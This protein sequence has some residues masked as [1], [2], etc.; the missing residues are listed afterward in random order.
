MPAARILSACLVCLLA[1]FAVPCRALSGTTA[2]SLKAA[3][4][5]APPDRERAD[6]LLAL[7]A[8]Y[9]EDS[10]LHSFRFA[11]QAAN[12]ARAHRLPDAQVQAE[13]AI[14]ACHDLVEQWPAAIGRYRSARSIAIANGLDLPALQAE[15]LLSEAFNSAAALDSTLHWK[16]VAL[17]HARRGREL[18]TEAQLLTYLGG[19]YKDLGRKREAIGYWHAALA[20]TRNLQRPVAQAMALNN[21]ADTYLDLKATDSAGRA[22]QAALD[23]LRA[24][25]SPRIESYVRTS[26]G[27]YHMQAGRPALA[28]GATRDAVALALQPG[29]DRHVAE[30]ALLQLSDFY[31]RQS[32]PGP[33]L[34]HYKQYILQRDSNRDAAR[35]AVDAR[36][37]VKYRFELE[38]AYNE[39]ER[40]NLRATSRLRLDAL[41][42]AGIAFLIIAILAIYVYISLRQ[43]KRK[44]RT[45]S[46][47]AQ[48]LRDQNE[49]I[50]ESLHEKEVLIKEVHHRV[51]NNLQVISALLQ[52]QGSRSTDPLVRQSLE[53]SQNRVLS[54]AFIHHN[55]YMHEDMQ[56]VEMRS[57]LAELIQHLG[58]VYVSVEKETEVELEV[59]PLSL[60]MDIAM[61][62]GLIVNELLSNSY[63]YAFA[64]LRHGRICLVLRSLNAE[65]CLLEYSD[66]GSG[67]H[68]DAAPSRKTLGLTLV[69]DLCRQLGGTPEIDGSRGFR[70]SLRF[71]CSPE[72]DET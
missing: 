72:D 59:D 53:A 48:L 26:L 11:H 2:D 70:F 66:N 33:A 39:S 7:A 21:L 20:A 52:L 58:S 57:F 28:I 5:A 13:I 62:V 41:V 50:Q 3:L 1:A 23:L 64:T 18:M 9:R 42:A 16:L 32:Q 45:I 55:L 25:P 68:T 19:Y 29:G 61:P 24:H 49:A 8:L 63:K 65:E 14:G 27:S 17:Q 4:R 43:N 54:I 51:K 56:R 35:K 40:Q 38:A 30:G 15:V 71:R 69:Q 10:L 37:V 36:A 12:V 22:L 34:E 6:I 47:Q 44:A 31:S 60:E 46:V 67:M